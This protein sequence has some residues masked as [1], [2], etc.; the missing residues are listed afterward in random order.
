MRALP[1]ETQV[2]SVSLA[3][4]LISSSHFYLGPGLCP[5]TPTSRAFI[6]AEEG[7]QATPPAPS[8]AVSVPG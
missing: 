7:D 6:S 8:N 3:L 5:E 2:Q 4:N 1:Q